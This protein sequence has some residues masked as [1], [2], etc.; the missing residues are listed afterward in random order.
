MKKINYILAVIL[1]ILL[2]LLTSCSETVETIPIGSGMYNPRYFNE[3]IYIDSL[4]YDRLE[5]EINSDGFKDKKGNNY[6]TI[7]DVYENKKDYCPSSN[8]VVVIYGEQTTLSCFNN[9]SYVVRAGCHFIDYN[10]H[11]GL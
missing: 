11:G 8:M 6:I 4:N 2:Y 7:V 10:E 1:L 3:Y 5:K 9:C